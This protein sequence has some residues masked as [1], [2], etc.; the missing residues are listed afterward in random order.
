MGPR[1]RERGN[2]ARQ[3]PVAGLV[4]A[5]MGPRS[6]ERGNLLLFGVAWE[7][8]LASMG[9]RSRERGNPPAMP[10]TRPMLL[11]QWGR[12]HVSAEMWYAL[13]GATYDVML[14]W[15]RAHVSAEM[16]S[17]SSARSADFSFNGAAL[18]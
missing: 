5:S 3:C 6:R 17:P 2:L 14:Q 15:G 13:L 1:S 8:R 10:A 18:T 9:P 4:F 11:L 7:S 12:A 16:T